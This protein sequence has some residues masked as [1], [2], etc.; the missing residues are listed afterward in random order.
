MSPQLKEIYERAQGKVQERPVSSQPLNE[1]PKTED[2]Y[3]Q[4]APDN[5]KHLPSD[6]SIYG[7]FGTAYRPN[8]IRDRTGIRTWDEQADFKCIVGD[9]IGRDRIFCNAI[10]S[11][12]EQTM[13]LQIYHNQP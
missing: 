12:E 4:A 1:L 7:P 9:T 10:P 3:R 2:I 13:G 6:E 8:K 11:L 5:M